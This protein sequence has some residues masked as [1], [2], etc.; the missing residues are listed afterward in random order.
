MLQ[1]ESVDALA[2]LTLMQ[3]Q[4]APTMRAACLHLTRIG[5]IIHRSRIFP[6]GEHSQEFRRE[7]AGRVRA[8]LTITR[9]DAS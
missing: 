1:W 6:V 3:C 8:T 2:D 7:T 4:R 9:R 5:D